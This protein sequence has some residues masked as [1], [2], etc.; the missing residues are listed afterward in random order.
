MMRIARSMMFA[1]ATCT[2]SLPAIAPSAGYPQE[3]SPPGQQALPAWVQRGIPR[4]GHARWSRSSAHGAFNR[5]MGRS[6][7]LPP[8]VSND[9]RTTRVWVAGGQYIEDTT[10]GTVEGPAVLA[11]GLW[12]N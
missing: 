4:A 9:I 12:T 1:A 5:T 7:D 8:I 6:P 10:E 2:L 3:A 11:A